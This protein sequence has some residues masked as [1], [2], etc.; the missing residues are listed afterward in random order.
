MKTFINAIPLGLIILLLA[1]GFA[2]GAF[3]DRFEEDPINYSKTKGNNPI[4]RL[5]QAL[6]TNTQT[7]EYDEQFGYLKAVL[8]ALNVSHET[9][10]LV[11]SKTSF[12]NRYIT[13]E[14]PRAIYYNDEV[15]IGTVPRGDVL[16][17]STTDPELGT[18]FYALPQNKNEAPRFLRQNNNCLQCHASTLTR[19]I[20]G[21]MVRSVFPDKDGYPILKAGTH[22]TTQESPLEERWG[23]WYVTGTHGDARHMGNVIA[24]ELERDA[25]LDKEAGA[26]HTTLDA[27]VNPEKYLTPHS[28]IV[29]L[30][31]LEHQSKVQN[32]ITTANFETRL[33]LKDQAVM[34]E[35]FERDPTQLSDSTKSRIAN[36]GDA[37]VDYML[38]VD[39]A[40]VV[41]PIT[42]TSN[43]TETFTANGLKDSSG[44]SLRDLDLDSRLFSYP[45][46]YLIYSAQ[47]D[48]LPDPMKEYVYQRLWTILSG[49]DDSNDYDH[50]NKRT[51]RA[52]LEIL[53]ETK[54][55]L[56]E[57]WANS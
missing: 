21:H 40:E 31:V 20:P 30:M 55:D 38:F 34:D 39:E 26:N 35:I 23:G 25:R 22:V 13:P 6:D 50:L 33:A 43:F 42:G 3:A 36:A 7:L 2:L 54:E 29:S 28:D 52:I 12:Q 17:V 48:G 1:L 47:F 32:L 44:R 53:S 45:L 56:P 10:V 14:S 5:Q 51:C 24:E 4:T 9:Q 15:Y 49:Q 57:Y 11:F 41:S 16:E 18:V 19:G 27:R 8:D 46:S 37:L